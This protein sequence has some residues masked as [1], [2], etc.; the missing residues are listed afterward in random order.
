[1][2]FSLPAS[3]QHAEQATEQVVDDRLP[4]I[5]VHESTMKL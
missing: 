1:M 4:D 3:R 5:K 2:D